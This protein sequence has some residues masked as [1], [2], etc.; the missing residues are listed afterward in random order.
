MTFFVCDVNETADASSRTVLGLSELLVGLVLS[1]SAIFAVVNPVVFSSYGGAQGGVF[2]QS[3]GPGVYERAYAVSSTPSQLAAV[4]WFRDTGEARSTALHELVE[5]PVASVAASTTALPGRT[6]VP[7]AGAAGASAA[8]SG[9]VVAVAVLQAG[10]ARS[11]LFGYTDVLVLVQ[12]Q[13]LDTGGGYVQVR[14]DVQEQAQGASS[15]LAGAAQGAW[16]A[17][18]AVAESSTP[19]LHVAAT[20]DVQSSAVASAAD[21]LPRLSAAW[22]VNTETL[23]MTRYTELPVSSVAVVGGRVLALG[24]GGLYEFAGGSDDGTPITCSALT[25]RVT[26]GSDQIK[27]LG[28]MV[29]SYSSTGAVELRVHVYGGAATGAFTYAMPAR[30]ADAPRANRIKVGKGLASKFWQFEWYGVGVRYDVSRVTVDVASST[31]R[32]I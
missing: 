32:R 29:L 7:S 15:A 16:G 20:G 14:Y 23:G 18:A 19:A 9:A 21:L 27:R 17:G 12:A 30:A 2:A 28:D 22:V 8:S 11:G 6:L 13:A 5:L 3:A 26:L 25:G 4:Q 24:D 31:T 10:E 1:I